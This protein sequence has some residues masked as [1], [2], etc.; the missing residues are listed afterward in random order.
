MPRVEL[1]LTEPQEQFV[2]CEETN[3]AI[4]GGLG[5]GKSRAGTARLT[6]LMLSDPGI[7]TAYYMPTYDLLKLR[8]IPGL[9]EDLQMFGLSYR[10]NKSDYSIIIDGLGT[11]IFRSYDNPNRI[12]A[13]EVAHSIVDELDTLKK[14]DAKRVWRKIDERNRQKSKMPNSIGCVTTPDQGYNGFIYQ[15]WYKEQP[16]GYVKI[17]A[18]TYSNPFLPAS[19]VENIRKNYDPLLAEMY[20]EGEIVNLNANKVYHFFNRVKHHSD[21]E[22]EQGDRLHIGLDFNIGGCC[23]VVFVMD[24]PG[25]IAVDEFVSHDTH[26]F[27]NNMTRYSEHK[28]IVY[29]D[30]SGSGRSTNATDTD[31][32]IIEK[33]GFT[34][35]APDSNP[36]VRNRINAMNSLISHG[37]YK[38]NTRKC[39][40][41]TNALE[42][43]GYTDK[44]EP[45]KFNEHP[46]IDDW[47]DAPGY[48]VH[49]RFPIQAPAP[50]VP[51][52][53]F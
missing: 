33:A 38:V 20:I 44:G 19:Y 30:A 12:I 36:G 3:P 1:A 17:K 10:V 7:N 6:Y 14:D 2:M 45:E 37:R 35:D 13:Y 18:P 22:I 11:V 31:I 21:R 49:Q 23:A 4:I 40:E 8:A 32:G 26:D 5:S 48:F 9:E 27:V 15:R 24:G 34:V 41:H 16:P 29:P 42:T 52:R 47:V 51:I 43:Q 53:M 39:P 28:V 46:A 25:V 50:A